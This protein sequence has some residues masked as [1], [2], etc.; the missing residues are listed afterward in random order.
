MFARS[1]AQ[2]NCILM[3]HANTPLPLAT[4]ARLADLAYAPAA[5]AIATLE[6][7]GLAVRSQRA[8]DDEFAANP[9]SAHYPMA[10]ATALVDLPLDAALS[11]QRVYM[12]YAYGSMS[13]P[14]GGSPASDLDLMLVGDIKSREQL[15]GRL[16][17][18]GERL[19]RAIDPF[20]LTPEE[21]EQGK[22]DGDLH[23][24]EALA[25]VRIMGSL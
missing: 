9:D 14:G 25:G 4:I 1:V 6:K 21:F 24:E 16:A 22:A 12:V 10:Y 23:I 7:R 5:S 3:L 18:V 8:G 19:G 2:V 11:G 20:M 17:A 15:T 13:R